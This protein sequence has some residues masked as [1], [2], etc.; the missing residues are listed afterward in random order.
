MPFIFLFLLL[1]PVSA[2][3]EEA[4]TRGVAVVPLTEAEPEIYTQL[5]DQSY[6]VFVG[7]DQFKD[8]GIQPL[9]FPSADAKAMRD[10]FV[11]ELGYLKEENTRL[12]VSSEGENQPDRVSIIRAI[13]WA[14]TSAGPEGC[15]VVQISTHGVEGYVLSEDSFRDSLKE[16]AVELAWVEETL[17]ES[18]SRK[19]LL[20][21]DACRE[22][23]TSDEAGEKAI[24][25][26]MSS[27]FAEAFSKAEGFV[28]LKS[29]S[30]GQYSYEMEEAGHGAFTHFLLEGLRG[31]VPASPE[32]LVTVTELGR[33][34]RDQVESWSRTKSGGIQSPLLSIFE[35]TGDLPLAVS[36]THLDTQA[37]EQRDELLR[38]LA[39]MFADAKLT[40]DQ[41]HLAEKALDSNE[42][43]RHKVV[44]DLLEGKVAPEYLAKLLPEEES[45]PIGQPGL[46]K[47]S[48]QAKD[49]LSNALALYLG[50]GKQSNVPEARL[51]AEK[52]ADS[53]DP[54]A[55]L[56][57]AWFKD[58][59]NA[60]YKRNPEEAATEARAVFDE[61]KRLAE[62]GDSQ[63]AAILGTALRDGLGTTQD[64]EQAKLWY[65]KA[66]DQV[67]VPAMVGL[68]NLFE[69]TQD[70]LEAEKLYTRA[71]ESGSSAVWGNLGT[72]YQNGQGIT[73]DDAKA[74]DCFQK[75]SDAGD[76]RCTSLLAASYQTGRGVPKD[77]AKAAELYAKAAELGYA[78]AMTNLG[79]LYESGR[80]V[81]KDEAKA[82][83]LFLQGAEAGDAEAMTNL[84][85]LYEIGRG[86]P[87]DQAK[88]TEW[89]TKAVEAGEPDAMTNLG[90]VHE[91]GR[92]VPKDEVKAAEL[93]ARGA[94]GGDPEG[95]TN[96]GHLYRD[97]RGVPKDE[98]L[99]MEWYQKGA[100]AGDSAGM[101]SIGYM[102]EYGKGVA[103]DVNKGTEW[104]RK[105][106]DAGNPTAMYNMGMM[107]EIG[108]GVPLDINAALEW[109][110]KAAE[111]GN[112]M[113][114]DALVRLG[115]RFTDGQ[116]GTVTDNQ[117]G[118]IWV[119]D[120]DTAGLSQALSLSDA[121][122]QCEA[123]EF[124]GYSD[125]R[126]PTY[127]ELTLL[128]AAGPSE[129]LTQK[130]STYWSL[131][132]NKDEV[133]SGSG[134]R[135]S[136]YVHF[137]GGSDGTG[138]ASQK[139]LVR[140][141][142]P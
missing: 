101:T 11:N 141:V 103:R 2:R 118:L 92:G 122:T 10:C 20:I 107:H 102:Y 22:K 50:I 25:G 35:A 93:Y 96:L 121:I 68:G 58:T 15:V 75:G 85:I 56:R 61:V 87:A 70:F 79:L 95:M 26:G 137:G 115:P 27:L 73:K 24:A 136:Q 106:A 54:V 36:K 135:A 84:G 86:V 43:A 132:I 108:S 63:A 111:N 72:L 130:P 117:T 78:I 57:R 127:N 110:K 48:K 105:G 76:T 3:C 69:T 64:L 44:E 40:R 33:W 90:V 83:E 1:F 6:G 71:A 39:Q 28:T 74:A 38:R 100:A 12:L 125:W 97:G 139:R 94:Q 128:K 37:Q 16:T 13:K 41:L 29:C 133:V 99:A 47:R 91:L 119:K 77:E 42:P 65:Q 49:Q 46:F 104:Y 30:K 124:G 112:Q 17:R 7:V 34:V 53:G 45:P 126:L 116:N 98:L 81:P 8:S 123:L 14:A 67:D 142:R 51:L 131:D 88:A 18:K 114:A 113:A 32:G 23:W 59:G 89:Y 31:A 5:K 60:G 62:S 109:Y 55:R 4:A 138:Y 19:R 52:L 129:S 80:G 9:R 21:F 140:P 82:R 134:T 66:I 120:P